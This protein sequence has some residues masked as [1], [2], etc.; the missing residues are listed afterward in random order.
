MRDDETLVHH[1]VSSVP[2]PALVMNYVAL[3]EKTNLYQLDN[4]REKGLKQ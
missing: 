2:N 3:K 1:V 4:V